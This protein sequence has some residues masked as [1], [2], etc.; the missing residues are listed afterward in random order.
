VLD[1]APTADVVVMAH[2]GFE[3]LDTFGG[4]LAAIPGTAPILI[5]CVRIPRSEVPTDAAARIAWLDAQWL[6][7]DQRV[8][9]LLRER[10]VMVAEAARRNR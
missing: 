9:E 10:N 2:A 5:D 6:V 1:G 4:I 7:L 8:D 3:G